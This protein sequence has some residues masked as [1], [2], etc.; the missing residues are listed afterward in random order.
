V[1]SERNFIVWA[2]PGLMTGLA[3]YDIASDDFQ[4]GQYGPADLAR[5]L[6]QLAKGRRSR[7]VLGYE[8]FIATSGGRKTSSSEHSQ[9]AIRVLDDW[10]Y[11]S[12]VQVLRSQPSSARNLGQVVWLRRLGW[13][14]PGKGHANDAAQHLLADLLKRQPMPPTIRARLFPGYTPRGTLA[15]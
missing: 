6:D 10:A 7:L 14:K 2:D 12:Q 11:V 1:S 8:K 13:Y 5:K 9:R 15:T 4:S 3:W